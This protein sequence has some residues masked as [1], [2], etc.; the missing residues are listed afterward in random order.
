MLV[1]FLKGIMN[2]INDHHHHVVTI[3][4]SAAA[5]RPFYGTHTE[6]VSKF[7]EFQCVRR[8]LSPVKKRF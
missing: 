8:L 5:G 7:T 1:P 3:L 6:V 4:M 2:V